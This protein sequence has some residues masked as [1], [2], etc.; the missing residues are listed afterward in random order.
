[1]LG[2]AKIGIFRAPPDV[3]GT[4]FQNALLVR[5]IQV[6]AGCTVGIE[7]SFLTFVGIGHG[8]QG[9][10]H[11]LGTTAEDT[12]MKGGELRCGQYLQP[13]AILESL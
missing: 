4:F 10:T 8:T 5:D 7:N 3:I 13:G 1:M 11:E 6:D 2:G 12:G 9:D